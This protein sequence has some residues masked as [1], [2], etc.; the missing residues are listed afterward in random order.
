MNALASQQQTHTASFIYYKWSK[1][2]PSLAVCI[3]FKNHYNF[4]VTKF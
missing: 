1:G 2:A 3:V 4:D